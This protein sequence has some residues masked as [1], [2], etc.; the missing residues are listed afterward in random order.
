MQNEHKPHKLIPTFKVPTFRIPSKQVILG[1]FSHCVHVTY[2]GAVALEGH[3]IY[4]TAGGL[5][6]ILVIL[7]FFLHFE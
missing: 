6:C 2:F 3:G 1:R 5:M 4:A 7:N